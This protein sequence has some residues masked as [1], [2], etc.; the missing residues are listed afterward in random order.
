[1]HTSLR[2]ADGGHRCLRLGQ[3]LPPN[4]RT[5]QLLRYGVSMQIADWRPNNT[6]H[7]VDWENPENNHFAL[8]EEVVLRGCFDGN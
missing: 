8:A 4:L 2:Q 6:V 7:L 1:M 3:P 5:Y